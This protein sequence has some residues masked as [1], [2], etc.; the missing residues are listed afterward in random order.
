MIPFPFRI[1]IESLFWFLIP[2][3]DGSL[4]HRSVESH[5]Q[6]VQPQESHEMSDFLTIRIHHKQKEHGKPSR[7]IEGS[8]MR[9]LESVFS[10]ANAEGLH[11]AFPFG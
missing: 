11:T 2:Y 5:L 10:D 8:P 9:F 7:Y 4:Q 1:S 3:L 6:L